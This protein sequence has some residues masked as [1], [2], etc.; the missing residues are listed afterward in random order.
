L[1]I[2]ASSMPIR[3][4][5]VIDPVD[6]DDVEITRSVMQRRLANMS[7][8]VGSESIVYNFAN[9]QFAIKDKTLESAMIKAINLKKLSIG[10]LTLPTNSTHSGKKANIMETAFAFRSMFFP[11]QFDSSFTNL[12]FKASSDILVSV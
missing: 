11:I 7:S 5:V 4:Y 2:E 3:L 6:A 8:S 10:E 12:D 1:V 9:F